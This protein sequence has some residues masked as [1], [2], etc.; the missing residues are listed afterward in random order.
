MKL[1]GLL[2][3]CTQSSASR[4][5]AQQQ[6]NSTAMKILQRFH[7]AQQKLCCKSYAARKIIFKRRHKPRR[8]RRAPSPARREST[9]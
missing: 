4:N 3:F 7:G 1:L 5:R 2:I 8:R 6:C 9:L